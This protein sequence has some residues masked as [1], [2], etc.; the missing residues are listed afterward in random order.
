MIE[1]VLS[2]KVIDSPHLIAKSVRELSL[3]NEVDI[4]PL[5]AASHRP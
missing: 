5:P 2:E 4:P 3:L 1:T